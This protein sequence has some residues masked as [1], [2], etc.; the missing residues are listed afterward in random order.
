MYDVIKMTA[1]IL[2]LKKDLTGV[3]ISG[4]L[5]KIT[6]GCGRCGCCWGNGCGGGVWGILRVVNLVVVVGGLN[7]VVVVATTG[8]LVTV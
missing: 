3:V 1:I 2:K 8:L 6:A 5:S 4:T 7:V